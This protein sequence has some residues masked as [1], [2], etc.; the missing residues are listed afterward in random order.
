MYVEPVA[1][2]GDQTLSSRSVCVWESV[3]VDTVSRH[4]WLTDWH[5]LLP[6]LKALQIHI[7]VYVYE[8]E[9]AD[10]RGDT[11]SVSPA[12]Q[13]YRRCVFMAVKAGLR[14]SSFTVPGACMSC[15]TSE[16][17]VS[18]YPE[19]LPNTLN[20]PPQ[21]NRVS[22]AWRQRCILGTKSQ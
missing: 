17:S 18:A 12:A 2:P 8:S 20:H 7:T 10:W 11:V 9:R 14:P 4:A 19:Y 21:K 15:A 22:H 3:C 6:C 16:A 1:R 5:A 13:R